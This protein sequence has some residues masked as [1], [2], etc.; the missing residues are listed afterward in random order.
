LFDG[1][2]RKKQKEEIYQTLDEPTHALWQRYAIAIV[3]LSCSGFLSII[4]LVTIISI[5]SR[6][7]SK[8]II[9][10]WIAIFCRMLSELNY[11]VDCL[12][13]D[14]FLVNSYRGIKSKTHKSSYKEYKIQLIKIN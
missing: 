1:K 11:K 8:I 2:Q 13:R 14:I 7:H 5:Y 12:L 3:F 10:Q 4:K 6:W 9:S